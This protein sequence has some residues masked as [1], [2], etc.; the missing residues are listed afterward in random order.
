MLQTGPH[1]FRVAV[2]AGET[3]QVVDVDVERLDEFHTRLMVG[4]RST[5]W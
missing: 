5:G 2:A 1:R 3:T 4:D